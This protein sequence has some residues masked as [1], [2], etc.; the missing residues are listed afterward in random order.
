MPLSGREIR[1]LPG[2][3]DPTPFVAITV[4]DTGVG[5]PE[6]NLPRVFDP[7]FTTK[8]EGSGLGLTTAYSIASRHGGQS[9]ARHFA[10]VDGGR[11]LHPDRAEPCDGQRQGHSGLLSEPYPT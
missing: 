5:I 6:H 1:G 2:Q 10:P 11:D 8:E 3:A 4:R 9:D 7:Y